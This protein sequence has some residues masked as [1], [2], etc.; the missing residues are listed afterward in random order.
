MVTPLDT[1]EPRVYTPIEG[2]STSG[3][4]PEKV[5]NFLLDMVPF[6]QFATPERREEFAQ[7]SGG[8]QAFWVGFD[9]ASLGLA[10]LA[11][12]GAASLV[13][14]FRGGKLGLDLFSKSLAPLRAMEQAEKGIIGAGRKAFVPLGL[15]ERIK[16]LYKLDDDMAG[17]LVKSA[18]TNWSAPDL[19]YT[20]GRSQTAF[21]GV[22]PELEKFF[23][24]RGQMLADYKKD[25]SYWKDT[26]PTQQASDFYIKQWQKIASERIGKEVKP[27]W[28][29]LLRV[30]ARPYMGQEAR[31]LTLG[32]ANA[33]LASNVVLDMLEKPAKFAKLFDP[34][35]AH[36]TP[37]IFLPPRKFSGY[38]E[39]L[40]GTYTEV[41]EKATGLFHH[42]NRYMFHKIGELNEMLEKAGAGKAKT[43]PA[44]GK[45]SFKP[46][47]KKAQWQELGLLARS[48]DDLAMMGATETERAS[49]LAAAD[50]KVAQL[51]SDVWRPWHDGLWADHFEFKVPQIFEK[52]SLNSHGQNQLANFLKGVAG[53]DGTRVGGAVDRLRRVIL[54]P[55]LDLPYETKQKE[56]GTLLETLRTAVAPDWFSVARKSDGVAA[57]EAV[58][59][60][61]KPR[62]KGSRTGFMN[63]LDN[64]AMRVRSDEYAGSIKRAYALAPR[65]AAYV[66]ARRKTDLV[67][68]LVLDTSRLLEGRARAQAS[69]LFVNPYLDDVVGKI[70]TLPEGYKDYYHQWLSRMLGEP[71]IMD[72]KVGKWLQSTIGPIEERWFGGSGMWDGRRVANLAYRIND[73]VYLGALGFKP[74]SAVKNLFQP[75]ITVPTDMG[76]VK[77]LYWLTRGYGKVLGPEGK[78]TR[79]YIK[80]IGAIQEYAPEI[81][82][83]P[84]TM[85]FGAAAKM[86][87]FRDLGMWLFQ[88]TDKFD[89]YVTG[90][91][92]LAKWDHYAKK[93]LSPDHFDLNMFKKKMMI[94]KRDDWIRRP[95]EE[96]LNA[97]PKGAR[98]TD[99]IAVI[100]DRAKEILVKDVIADTQWLYGIPDSPL[101]LSKWGAVS[102][103]G[104]I[105]QS[106][107]MNY[108]G[109]L[110]KWFRGVG[111]IDGSP[112][113]NRFTTWLTSSAIAGAMLTKGMGFKPSTATGMIGFGPLPSEM[114]EFSVPPAWQPVYYGL[115]AVTGILKEAGGTLAGEDFDMAPVTRRLKQL[116]RSTYMFFP[117][118]LQLERMARMAAEGGKVGLL[119][120][121]VGF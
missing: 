64:Y 31:N 77:D 43:D 90:G 2:P 99:E 20:T 45:M 47:I 119:K 113:L 3:F 105:F 93:F 78:A 95:I 114:S 68:P 67:E 58:Q 83:K 24:E 71:S 85:A 55:A 13:R 117:G 30:Q 94:H 115:S 23:G 75:L 36:W 51:W 16:T 107:W 10:G 100:A 37:T 41:Y 44:T 61:L 14:A 79:D 101:A 116:G 26:S 35:Y 54:N 12:K 88:N 25:I 18:Q 22:P 110:E 121:M 5:G 11:Y 92:V 4:T 120:S 27:D 66:K 1:P 74:F 70:K 108:M 86:E 59:K 39:R 52:H 60:A 15:H 57:V 17:E 40:F 87:K 56:I 96:I 98:S 73:M 84:K 21:K 48:M 38:G 32:T 104:L 50:P 65:E 102:R 103:T 63:Y 53:T 46:T 19:W 97:V 34:G 9:L 82:L 6:G 29:E 112:D 49:R 76:G 28:N 33:Q 118:G 106:W 89:R 80:A 72:E 81:Y 69:E 62:Q 109:A 91:A 111:R 7:K 8:E 42:K